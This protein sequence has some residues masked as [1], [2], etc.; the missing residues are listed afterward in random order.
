MA[1]HRPRKPRPFKQVGSPSSRPLL[2]GA[3][4][5]LSMLRRLEKQ[6]EQA[7]RKIAAEQRRQERRARRI[8]DPNDLFSQTAPDTYED[9]TT[10]VDAPQQLMPW[11]T[12]PS[13]AAV[14]PGGVITDQP[15]PSART[16]GSGALMPW[17]AGVEE[18]L[19]PFEVLEVNE[20]TATEWYAPTKSSYP[21]RP[22]TLT[23]RYDRQRRILTI[24]YRNGGTY[25]YFDVP[26]TIWYRIKQVRSPGRFIDRNIRGVYQYERVSL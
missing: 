24:Q 7:Q 4:S 8:P 2:R 21:P 11:M 23:M 19:N 13:D 3:E 10:S 14:G 9:L 12:N 15:P 16:P 6:Y 1:T 22:R 18:E 26:G 20:P 5:G 25:D 17:M